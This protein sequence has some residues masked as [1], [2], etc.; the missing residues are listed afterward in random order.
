VRKFFAHLLV[1]RLEQPC[2][3]SRPRLASEPE[4]TPIARAHRREF[5]AA[6]ES[7]RR[8][9]GAAAGAESAAVAPEATA[10]TYEPR[11]PYAAP[12]LELYD[13]LHE[14]HHCVALELAAWSRGMRAEPPTLP[15]LHVDT[16]VLDLEE[17]RVIWVRESELGKGV[18]ALE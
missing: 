6:A 7:V 8:A 1:F 17:D 16:P 4:P 13:E 11:R 5:H 9:A 10:S 2:G 18:V 3:W 14:Q 15:T 12:A